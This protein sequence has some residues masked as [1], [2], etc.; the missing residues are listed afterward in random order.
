[1]PKRKATARWE[2]TLTGGNGE[3]S[4]ES[5][6]FKGRYSYG[7]RFENQPGTNPEE[8]LGAAH[9][10]CFSMALSLL[11][12]K[13]GFTPKRIDTRADVTIEKVGD[14]FKISGITLNT[15]A[16]APGMDESTFQQQAQAAKKNCPVSQA[17]Q[18]VDIRLSAELVA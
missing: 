10:G 2:G 9:A 15:T 3:L 6:A 12:E 11:I 1:M 4:V 5:G 8:L 13:A 14:E 16:E 7:S 17:L 18:A